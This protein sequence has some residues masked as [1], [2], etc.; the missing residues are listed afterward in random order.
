MKDVKRKGREGFFAK[1]A[2]SPFLALLHVLCIERY[3]TIITNQ[4][5]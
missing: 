2:K 3:V 4:T 1:V 5:T